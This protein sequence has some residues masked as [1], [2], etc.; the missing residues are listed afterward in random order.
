MKS[1]WK[2]C[3]YCSHSLVNIQEKA[4]GLVPT[5][6]VNKS[7]FQARATAVISS[8]EEKKARRNRIGQGLVVYGILQLIIVSF[9][10]YL[11][12]EVFNMWYIKVYSIYDNFKLMIGGFASMGEDL[13][14]GLSFN[15]IQREPMFIVIIGTMI[16]GM[17]IGLMGA[18][19]RSRGVA[20][21]GGLLLMVS[22]LIILVVIGGG[23]G[24]FGEIADI[25]GFL[26]QNLLYGSY[27]DISGTASWGI[28][29]GTIIPL[30]SGI[31]MIVGGT[32]LE[33]KPVSIKNE[34]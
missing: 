4:P 30:I 16:I 6:R 23:V 10:F 9:L 2:V 26:G 28:G 1:D 31:I 25:I 24:M 5:Q 15:Q 3:P 14:S 12:P 32:L 22:F 29:V 27:R 11:A 13:G 7:L 19:A 33:R 17:I 34:R 21:G 20:I 18:G 8:E